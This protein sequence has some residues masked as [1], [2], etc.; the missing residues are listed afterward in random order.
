V[1]GRGGA[2]EERTR[3]GG[4]SPEVFRGLIHYLPPGARGRLLPRGIVELPRPAPGASAEALAV[5]RR[6]GPA[7]ARIRG[8]YERALRATP[9]LAGEL[10]LRISVSRE[11]A[12]TSVATPASTVG[13]E[14][15]ACVRAVL[16]QWH[17]AEPLDAA[18]SAERTLK[19][20]PA[21]AERPVSD[22]G[23]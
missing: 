4:L 22:A 10:T 21:P 15:P 13:A 8:C 14:V 17:V 20:R 2:D 6:L 1:G 16:L 5:D 23:R 3:L 18:F 19:L 9:A 12:V 11:G 7:L